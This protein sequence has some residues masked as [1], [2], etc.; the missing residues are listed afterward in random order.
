MAVS[1]S[2]YE[3]EIRLIKK[4]LQKAPGRKTYVDSEFFLVTVSGLKLN[5]H[6]RE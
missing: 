3:E 5:L 1:D 6:Q 2:A 4:D